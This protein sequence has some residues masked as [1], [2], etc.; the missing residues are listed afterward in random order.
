[1]VVKAKTKSE[2]RLM[3]EAELFPGL[4]S[5][6]DREEFSRLDSKKKK[7]NGLIH[8]IDSSDIIMPDPVYDDDFDIVAL[9]QSAEDPVT[10]T[11]RNLKID[12]RDLPQAKNFYDFAMNI[13]GKESSVPWARQ[14]WTGMLLF[15]ECCTAC[16]KPRMLNIHNVDKKM[17]AEQLNREMVFLEH[18]VCPKCGRHKWD[19]IKNH[20]LR[21]YQQLVNILG[22]RSGKSSSAA[23]YAAYMTHRYLKFPDLASMARSD[24]QAS[25]ELTGTF[26][27]LNFN[28]AIG[29]LW[30]P[31][32]KL[33]EK[34]TWFMDMF[35]LLDHYKEKYGKELYRNST[36]YL[37]F[38]YKNLKF[39]PSG[40]RS[41]TLRGDTRIFALLDELGLFPL[42]TGDEEEDEQSERANADE[43]HKSLSRSLTTVQNVRNR[44]LREGY[45]SVPPSLLLSVSSPISQRDKMMRL[46]RQ[47]KTPEGEK[48]ILAINL[49]TWEANPGM[50]RDDPTIALAYSENY[51]K[52]ERDYGAN[53]P[54]V[55]SPFIRA[56]DVEDIWVNKGSTHILEYCYENPG[57]LYGKLK[58]ISAVKWPSLITM[59]AGHVNNSFTITA[60]HYDFDAQKTVCSTIIECMPHDGR[61]V[62]FNLIYEHVIKVLAKELNAVALLADQ[63]N[64]I[65]LLYRIKDD[66]GNNPLGKP[67]VLAKQHSPT[68][69]DF[70]LLLSMCRNKNLLFPRVPETDKEMIDTGNVDDWRIQMLHKPVSHLYL[71]MLTVKDVGE[72]KCPTKGD[73]YTDDIFRSLV[74]LA[75]KIHEPKI[76]ARLQEARGWASDASRIAMP[77]PG[78]ASRSGASIRGLR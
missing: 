74:L 7:K 39:Y 53:P 27:S 60:G 57:E 55:Q 3:A 24:M 38:G 11:L 31:Y 50:E 9:M 56:H 1:M 44:L 48:Y 73:G 72:F 17:P 30:T 10:G 41:T 25:T 62:N 61:R 23:V 13:V 65:D 51:E 40:P 20:G 76:M 67:K 42:P 18:G 66:M 6:E 46:M 12:D 54:S 64:S 75:S 77:M 43:A 22:Q 52:A 14:M 59:D 70:D 8:E 32:K 68:R 45:S 2:K 58:R 69:K 28:K 37:S 19:L 26:V 5:F 63:W 34:S 49:A 29:V 47:S 15:G 16:T 21:N 36:L 4:M 33:I 35:S 71:Q 78:F